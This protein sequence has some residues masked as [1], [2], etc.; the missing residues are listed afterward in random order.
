MRK[1][2]RKMY[3]FSF[4]Q[5]DEQIAEIRDAVQELMDYVSVDGQRCINIRETEDDNYVRIFDDNAYV[6]TSTLT[7]YHT[8]TQP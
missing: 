7:A 8:R 3:P 1:E 4:P 5:G 6:L 2:A